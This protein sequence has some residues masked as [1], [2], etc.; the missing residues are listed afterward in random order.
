MANY[1]DND[2]T[3]Y[4]LAKLKLLF[5]EKTEIPTKTSD[6]TNDNLIAAPNGA[7]AGQLLAYN[8]TDWVAANAPATGVISF[9][10]RGG[11]VTP[12]NG[13]YT[14]A[15][16]GARADNWMPSAADVGA[17]PANAVGSA[18]GV[19]PLGADSK[20]SST[21]LPSYVDDVIEAYTIAGAT[22]LSGEW[23]TLTQGST[24]PLTPEQ[25]KIYIVMSS[26]DYQN[27]EYRWGGTTY[28][29]IADSGLTPMT[30]SQIDEIFEEE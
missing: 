20:V 27:M 1:L 22:P 5:A 11:V 26:G 17:V 28:V 16:V 13:D 3:R 19:C 9:N 29:K 14:A 18:S 30:N 7:S 8:G 6:L 15:M 23:L 12:A 10:G 24:S 2:A 4:F 25:G 21:Y